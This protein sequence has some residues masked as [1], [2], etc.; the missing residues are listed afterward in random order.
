MGT[1]IHAFIEFDT[2][3]GRLREFSRGQLAIP[4]EYA[5]FHALAGVRPQSDEPP[6][7]PPRGLPVRVSDAVLRAYFT[8]VF[9]DEDVA[10]RPRP[11]S[12]PFYLLRSEVEGDPHYL[13]CERRGC[14]EDLRWLL[15]DPDWYT[16]S[17][18]TYLE[19]LAAISH[20]G[21]AL[22]DRSVE[23]R[24]AVEAMAELAN[25]S[26]PDRVRLVFWFDN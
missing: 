18:L 12:V 19:V 6:L 15:A 2:Q 26:G 20:L 24:A 10:A 4:P 1:D 17:W 13:R 8:P 25:E 9:A 3:G 23:F 14:P 5:L 21:L 11:R 22:A 16:P 7:F